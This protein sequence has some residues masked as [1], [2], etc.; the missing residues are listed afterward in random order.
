MNPGRVCPGKYF[1]LRTVYLV[2]TCVLSVFD[3]G[4]VLNED[5]NPQIPR[6]ELD[7]TTVRYVFLELSMHIAADVDR[8]STQHQGSQTFRMHYQA[9]FRRGHKA[10]KGNP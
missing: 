4:P 1:A 6:L 2:V 3:I 10:S 8:L 7:N 5:G 9:S